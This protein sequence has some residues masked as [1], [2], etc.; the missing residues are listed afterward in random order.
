[1]LLL[2]RGM[3]TGFLSKEHSMIVKIKSKNTRGVRK[4]H[5]HEDWILGHEYMPKGGGG[6]IYVKVHF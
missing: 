3:D 1:M 2:E 4:M 5:I 6:H